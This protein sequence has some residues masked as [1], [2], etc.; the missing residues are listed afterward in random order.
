MRIFLLAGTIAL[1]ALAYAGAGA[2]SAFQAQNSAAT[3]DETERLNQEANA[4]VQRQA[5]ERARVMARIR[6]NEE[7]NARIDRDNERRQQEYQ[8]QMRV[9][10]AAVAAE[11]ARYDAEMARYRA[12]QAEAERQNAR[13]GGRAS[14]ETRA[15]TERAAPQR[16]AERT[17]AASTSGLSCADQV[18]RNRQRGR[19]IGGALGGVAGLVGG[20][21]LG[22][23]ARI[24]VAVAAV[25]VGALI[26]DAIASRLDCR[27]REQ[28][29]QAT[30]QAVEG[31]VGTTITW[32]SETR[33][34]VTG[35]STVTA[36]EAP[37][38]AS[39]NSTVPATRTPANPAGAS[40]AARTP[41]ATAAASPETSPCLTVTDV[42]IVD[43]EETRAPKRMCRRP[44]T[45]RYVRV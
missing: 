21:Q 40:T 5:E 25:P 44:P 17:R 27:E 2:H 14:S 22:N 31:G 24:G 19:A 16:T 15:S 43:G 29:A 34:N 42:I 30:E 32:R 10:D 4:R 1:A 39:R 3:A 33:P 12:Q 38:V 35:T 26:G 36:V 13:R 7:N 45:N 37:V 9:R 8:E 28:A 41:V 11:Q 20:R 23:A 6:A 18:R